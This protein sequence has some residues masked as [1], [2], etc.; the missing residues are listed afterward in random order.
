MINNSKQEQEAF[1]KYDVGDIVYIV[2]EYP[3]WR[4]VKG[5]VTA[6]YESVKVVVCAF[7]NDILEY[8][9]VHIQPSRTKQ[10]ALDHALWELDNKLFKLSLEEE[11]I[12]KR[13]NSLRDS[14]GEV[15]EKEN[16]KDV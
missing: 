5:F 9:I 7:E 3:R 16:N 4:F 6:T 10:E 13:K 12:I 14:L 8:K 2:E 15:W 1:D 11:A